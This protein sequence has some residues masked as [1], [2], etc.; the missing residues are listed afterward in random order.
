LTIILAGYK[1]DIEN[2]LYAANSGMSSRFQD[3][4]FDDFDET[5]L[6]LIWKLRCRETGWTCDESVAQVAARR[7]GRQRGS[8]GFGN[9]RA[10]R[11]LFDASVGEAKLRY[12]TSAKPKPTLIVTDVIGREPTRGN[13]P[14][15]DAALAEL[16]AMVGIP[17]VK[18]AVTALVDLAR[19]NYEHELRGERTDPVVLNRLFLGNPGTGKTSVGMCKQLFVF[20]ISHSGTVW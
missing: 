8:K 17:R 5:Q 10:V 1:D 7:V 3:V 13:I 12:L 19:N 9:A 14:A 2:K 18:A 16:D 11:S 4:Q 20:S 15:L 6:A